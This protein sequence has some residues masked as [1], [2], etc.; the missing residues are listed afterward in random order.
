MFL[1]KGGSPRA[2]ARFKGAQSLDRAVAFKKATQNNRLVCANIVLDKSKCEK[3]KKR[4]IKLT[5]LEKIISSSQG[6]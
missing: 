6:R 5:I 4:S 2:V 3:P 1:F